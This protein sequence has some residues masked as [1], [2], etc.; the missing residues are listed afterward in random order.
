MEKNNFDKINKFRKRGIITSIITFLI[1]PIL[2]F[3]IPK[4]FFMDF[5]P[6]AIAFVIMLIMTL[7][8]TSLFNTLK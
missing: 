6:F 1:I 5:E 3:A 7:L 8:W 4:E 2:F